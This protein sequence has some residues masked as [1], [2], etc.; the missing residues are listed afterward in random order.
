MTTAQSFQV[1]GVVDGVPIGVFDRFSGG[2]ITAEV[3]KYRPG[4][5]A[6]ENTS[7]ALPTYGD[8]TIGRELDLTRDLELHRRLAGRV[9]R[10]LA[11]VSKQAL[12]ENGAPV[13]RPVTYTGRLSGMTDPD[14]DSTSSERAQFD[15]TFVI[16]G[17]D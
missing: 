6:E 9:G 5:M 15:M 14:V 8:A 4:G 16:T 13:G 1:T 2:E 10:A 11:S 17:R 3:N 12:D 7:H